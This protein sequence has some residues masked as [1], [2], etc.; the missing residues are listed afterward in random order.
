MRQ[1]TDLLFGQTTT[2]KSAVIYSRLQG[3]V[4]V[5]DRRL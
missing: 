5:F 4:A 2:G 3:A 1:I